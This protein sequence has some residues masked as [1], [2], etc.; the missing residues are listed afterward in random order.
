MVTYKWRIRRS[1]FWKIS[2]SYL[3]VLVIPILIS[4]FV[5]KTAVQA[6]KKDAMQH[7]LQMLEQTRLIMD[8]RL[9]EIEGIGRQI[10]LD[11]KMNSLM[12]AR[13]IEEGSPKQYLV[14]KSVHDSPNFHPINTFVLNHFV[15]FRNNSVV[16]SSDTAF[17]DIEWFWKS[18]F[19]DNAS[20]DKQQF[21]RMLWE[22]FHQ[23][24]F[25]T[26][27]QVT[28][29]KKQ[30][31][32]LYYL[33]S[34]PV[35]AINNPL[36]V[37]LILIDQYQINQ[38]LSKLDIGVRGL[39]Y[40]SDNEG[41]IVTSVTGKQ[42]KIAPEELEGTSNKDGFFKT[43]HGE[44]LYI[45]QVVSSLNGWKYVS[46]VPASMVLSKVHHIK[47]VTTAAALITIVLGTFLAF[48]LGYRDWKP[49]KQLLQ[50]LRGWMGSGEE[51][52]TN[53]YSYL[54]DSI[55]QLIQNH[56]QL[57][58]KVQEHIPLLQQAFFRRLLY[59]EF[60]NDKEIEIFQ[61]NIGMELSDRSFFVLLLRLDEGKGNT[62]EASLEEIRMLKIVINNAIEGYMKHLTY[63]Q[64]DIDEY[65]FALIIEYHD[66]DKERQNG[67]E[68][69]IKIMQNITSS[70]DHLCQMRL[71]FA[72]GRI[73]KGI[74]D[75]SMSFYEA[76]QALEYVLSKNQEQRFACYEDIPQESDK[77]YFPIDLELRLVNSIKSGNQTD[78]EQVL[79]LLYNE[80]FATR[81]LSLPDAEQF[82]Y[83]MI[84]AVS[85]GIDQT[86]DMAIHELYN[87]IQQRNEVIEEL[88]IKIGK[89]FLGYCEAIHFNDQCAKTELRNQV[90][91]FI[92]QNFVRDDLTLAMV[93]DE[94][95]ITE[96]M[97]YHLI[98]DYLGMTFSDYIESLRITRACELLRN[99]EVAIKEVA[100][101]VG[102]SSDRSFRRAFKRVMGVS[103]MA[104][105]S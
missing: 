25:L 51:G 87:E 16:I 37:V 78:V 86:K 13:D 69:V 5:Y 101:M 47:N 24:T 22:Q 91:V 34:F 72:F 102:Y 76:K 23:S 18:L 95:K 41:N 105:S 19:R 4:S 40:I 96:T 32:V 103:P 98:K 56:Q 61:S 75:I 64:Y 53:E 58:E 80:N 17:P 29:D 52:H 49:I 57:N 45:S 28:L 77:Y 74:R 26:G 54:K 88:F 43:D 63:F 83:L 12:N 15:F 97:L 9:K 27:S 68:G 73:Y 84:G 48:F 33:H 104:Y 62:S 85:R 36:G 31:Q 71:S 79:T 11:S 3:L 55:S 38:L 92:Q 82:L 93:A 67:I 21:Q 35:D 10:V 66:E 44:Q 94:F 8:A 46:A 65:K 99:R 20:L 39:I 30:H 81:N 89:A 42:T 6:V 60:I 1:L 14:W 90:K 50:Q 100:L 59:G 70:L 7:N 2:V